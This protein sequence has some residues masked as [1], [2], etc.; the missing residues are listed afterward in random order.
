MPAELYGALME[1]KSDVSAATLCH[2]SLT[3]QQGLTSQTPEKNLPASP[4][5]Y[6]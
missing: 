1:G 5:L 6:Q 4:L 3:Q 2:M